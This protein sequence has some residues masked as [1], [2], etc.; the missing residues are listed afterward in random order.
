MLFYW[1]H[2]NLTHN[3]PE[4]FYIFTWLRLQLGDIYRKFK[5]KER[6]DNSKFETFYVLEFVNLVI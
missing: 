2:I 5:A 6:A 4:V 3:L 1:Q